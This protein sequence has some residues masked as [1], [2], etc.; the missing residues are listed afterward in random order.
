MDLSRHHSAVGVR[1]G[2][3]AVATALVT[4]ALMTAACSGADTASQGTPAT[5]SSRSSPAATSASPTSTEGGAALRRAVIATRL[6]VPWGLAFLPDGTALVTLRDRAEVVRIGVGSTTVVGAVPGVQ[7]DGEGGLLGIALSPDFASDHQV[8]L[9]FTGAEDNRIVRGT[10][11]GGRLT[12]IRPIFTGI[13][14]AGHHDGGR[15]AFG[16]DGFLYAGTGD[17][18]D[19]EQAQDRTAL[20]G[21][22]L[23]LTREGRPAPGNPFP[24]SPVWSY[25]HRNVQGLA[26]DA[27]GRM[28]ASEFGQ[29]T[30]DELNEIVPGGNYGWPRV[31]GIANDRRF[32][33]PL[34]QWSTAEASPSGIA[35]GPDGAVYMAALRGEA[36]WRIPLERN[37]VGE[38]QRLLANSFGRLRTVELAPDGRLWVVTSNTFRGDPRRDDDRVIAFPVSSL[39]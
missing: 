3:R 10:F 25:G 19:S 20:G 36:L 18:G 29:N 21:K 24:G 30:W 4:C 7:P 23:R 31:E 6:E 17:A 37:R 22:I 13:P 27:S 5:L 32:R 26:W 16:P 11:D 9:Y 34:R 8:F 35:I 15:I 14:R 33:N 12:G 2:V 1:G 38:P 28:F 39:R